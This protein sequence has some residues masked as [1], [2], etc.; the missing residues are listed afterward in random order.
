MR[1]ARMR[2]FAVRAFEGQ[3]RRVFALGQ[4]RLATLGPAF[5]ATRFE[6]V[7]TAPAAESPPRGQ[8]PSLSSRTPHVATSA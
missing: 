7:A 4:S 3:T 8:L 6:S 2:G 5:G 1:H